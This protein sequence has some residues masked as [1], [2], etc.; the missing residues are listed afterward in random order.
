MSK[1]PGD[2]L[3]VCASCEWIFKTGGFTCPKCQFGSY[4]A[5]WVYG[6][7]AYTYFKNQHPWKTK[8]MFAYEMKLNTEIDAAKPHPLPMDFLRSA[9]QIKQPQPEAR[10]KTTKDTKS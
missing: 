5:Y 2:V 6:R 10:C 3:R 7:K 8:K 1:K 4:G 9:L